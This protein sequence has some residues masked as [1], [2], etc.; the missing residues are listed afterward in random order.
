MNTSLNFWVHGAKETLPGLADRQYSIMDL[1]LQILWFI[2]TLFYW[3]TCSGAGELHL[4][5]GA[6]FI[7]EAPSELLEA[8]I[9]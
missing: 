1:R 6:A 5:N 4:Q 9:C 7:Y 8:S 3:R 2:L